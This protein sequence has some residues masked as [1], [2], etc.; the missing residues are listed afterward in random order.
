MDN[1]KK[2]LNG[3]LAL[4]NERLGGIEKS[5]NQLVK[6]L[7]PLTMNTQCQSV[8]S[9]KLLC[10]VPLSTSDL[11]AVVESRREQRRLYLEE[12]LRWHKSHKLPTDQIEKAL[13]RVQRQLLLR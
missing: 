1:D 7:Q 10:A 5:L 9:A 6:G 3:Q 12:E 8:S 13:L 11:E 2:T 4:L